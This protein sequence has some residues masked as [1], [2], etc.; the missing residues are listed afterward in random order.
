M[1]A[2]AQVVI[3]GKDDSFIAVSLGR[4]CQINV[5]ISSRLWHVAHASDLLYLGGTSDQFIRRK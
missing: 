2:N 3:D 4:F 1:V 5:P